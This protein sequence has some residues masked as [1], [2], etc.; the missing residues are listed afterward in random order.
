MCSKECHRKTEFD[1]QEDKNYNYRRNTQQTKTMK[2]LKLLKILLISIQS[3][4]QMEIA[5]KAET[6]K[7]SIGIIRKDQE[8]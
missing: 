7:E 8:Q 2:T 6:Q 4:I 3:S 1:H 5:K